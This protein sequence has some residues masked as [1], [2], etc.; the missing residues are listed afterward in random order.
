MQW[1]AN[2]ENVKHWQRFSED[3]KT[4]AGRLCYADLLDEWKS[5]VV[6]RGF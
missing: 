2:N 6:D 3:E 5:S 1:T 4:W